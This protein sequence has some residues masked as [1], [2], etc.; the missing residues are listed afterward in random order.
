MTSSR[1][2]T[3]VKPR[4]ARNEESSRRT[5]GATKIPRIGSLAVSRDLTNAVLRRV[6]NARNDPRVHA[7]VPI[8]HFIFYC[9]SCYQIYRRPRCSRRFLHARVF[10]PR[11]S[12]DSRFDSRSSCRP[13][14]IRRIDPLNFPILS[15]RPMNRSNGSDE[16][17]RR[18]QR[19]K[20]EAGQQRTATTESRRR[21]QPR[22]RRNRRNG[23]IWSDR[24]N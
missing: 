13:V 5:I 18:E 9:A 6:V 16:R 17:Q 23:R 12:V 8:T 3:I 10:Y 7:A 24:S 21:A 2:E 14:S 19:E 11:A 4:N 1:L 15:S 22:N 20:L